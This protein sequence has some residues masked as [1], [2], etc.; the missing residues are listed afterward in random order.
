MVGQECGQTAVGQRVAQQALDG[1]ERARRHVGARIEAGHDVLRMADRGGE[2]L[3]GVAVVAVDLHDPAHE[4][5][6]VGADVVQTA[7]ERRHVGRTCLGGEQ[8]LTG[9]EDE[10]AVGADS[11][12]R[13][14]LHGADTLGRARQLHHDAGVQCGQLLALAHHALEIGGDHLGAHVAIDDVADFD[15]V[16]AACLLA[17]DVL[18]GHQ[19]R[20]GRHAVEHAHFVGL[21]DLGQ[22]CGINEKFHKTVIFGIRGFKVTQ[23]NRD[24]RSS[25]RFFAPQR[26]PAPQRRGDTRTERPRHGQMMRK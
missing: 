18:L 2:H 26:R 9:R 15:V 20:I 10:R 22:V 3:G 11:L 1:R 4:L 6:A 5:H 16:T 13:E 17:A 14:I 19:R 7:H 21:A 24:A 23:K 8:R 12:L 25:G